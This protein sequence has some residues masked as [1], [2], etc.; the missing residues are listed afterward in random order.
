MNNIE[1]SKEE[2][3][4]LSE[5]NK[6]DIN[7][8][9]NI[10]AIFDIVK[11]TNTSNEI[12][13]RGN[14]D[15][16]PVNTLSKIKEILSAKKIIKDDSGKDQE[17]PVYQEDEKVKIIFGLLAEKGINLLDNLEKIL[18]KDGYR[19]GSGGDGSFQQGSEKLVVI[20]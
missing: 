18:E 1:N 10:E 19:Y 11:N 12:S 13:K 4:K 3:K 7:P 8:N 15:H 6:S 2:L 5:L 9:I 17:V 16:T 20:S 14:Y